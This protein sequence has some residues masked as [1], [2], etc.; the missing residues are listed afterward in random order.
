MDDL[1][2]VS[3]ILGYQANPMFDEELFHLDDDDDEISNENHLQ[4]IHNLN[5]SSSNNNNNTQSFDNSG[6]SY[7]ASSAFDNSGRSFG[8]TSAFDASGCSTGAASAFD[9]LGRS[10]GA[11]SAFDASGRSSIAALIS[12]LKTPPLNYQ[13]RTLTQS[14]LKNK[15]EGGS[16]NS[17]AFHTSQRQNNVW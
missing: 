9:A 13:G 11:A 8:A 5:S 6:C 17:L 12:P 4:Q 2:S 1:D 7:G 16:T 15:N 10:T 3:D 14:L